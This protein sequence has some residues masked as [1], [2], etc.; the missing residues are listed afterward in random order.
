MTDEITTGQASDQVLVF[1]YGRMKQGGANHGILAQSKF[2]GGAVTA[3]LYTLVDLG[4]FP[5]LK[6]DGQR[7]IHG[8]LYAVDPQT[9]ANIDEL[10]DHPDTFRRDTLTLEDGR[11]V[12]GYVLPASQAAGFPHMNEVVWGEVLAS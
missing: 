11:E 6:K 3:P 4:G 10:E 9:L 1:V 2:I 5:G 12:V 8:E 7:A